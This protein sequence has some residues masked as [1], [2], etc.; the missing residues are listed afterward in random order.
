MQ[1]VSKYKDV[2][3]MLNDL[4]RKVPGLKRG[5]N[6]DS[7]TPRAADEW[8]DLTGTE[9]LYSL[10]DDSAARFSDR[11]CVNFLGKSYSYAEISDLVNRA[12]QGFQQIGVVKGTRVGLCLPNS[13]YFVICYFAI[14]KA[15][16]TV[17]NYNPLYVRREIEHQIEDSGTEIMVTLDLRQLY[18][19]VAQALDS[20]GLKKIVICQMGDILPPVKGL[21]FSTLK[22][23]ELA[24]IPEDL[25]HIRYDMLVNTDGAPDPVEYDVNKDVAVLQYTGGTTGIPK[26]AM[27]T[28]GNLIA[29]TRQVESLVATVEGEERILAVLP[30]FHVFA[31]T[32]IMNHGISMGAE[33]IL[34]PRFDLEQVLKTLESKKPT[35]FH[36]VPTIY[37]AIIGHE[38]L[39]K[40]DLTCLKFCISGGAPL[41]PDLKRRFEERTGCFLCEGYG[42]SEA[43]PVVACNPFDGSAKD[44]SI[45]RLLPAT[46]VKILSLDPPHAEVDQGERGE[47]C[48]R[49]PQVMSGYWRRPEETAKVLRDGYLHTGDV[50]YRD[51]DGF[52]FLVDR[53][54]DLIICSGY[55]VYPRVIEDAIHMHPAVAEVTVV[56]IADDYRGETPKAFVKLVAGASLT[57]DELAQFLEDKL[58][59]IEQPEFIEF[60]EELPKT[61][62]GKLS[63]K[64]LVAEEETKRNNGDDSESAKISDLSS[65]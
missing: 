10:L 30:F 53:V 40:Y 12:A 4:M 8:S 24:D 63:K 14:L 47:V 61:M 44:G 43:S 15:G 36:A 16:G 2:R 28:H 18:P 21:L 64:E 26:G 25:R 49:G 3:V 17:V 60:R 31:M 32:A 56:G 19:K 48:V 58:S 55:N 62:I 59:P 9:P 41:P 65:N 27:L 13:P 5:G 1:Y 51:E 33:L 57:E 34:L 50:G 6:D 45:G 29:N 42:L 7:R 46:E 11:P 52:L 37:T 23:S 35:I 54:K 20:T 39:D 38:D 22:R